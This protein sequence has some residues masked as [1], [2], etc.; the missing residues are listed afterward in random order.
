MNLIKRKQFQKK[1]DDKKMMIK[2]LIKKSIKLCD[3]NALL[4]KLYFNKSYRFRRDNDYISTAI[5][6]TISPSDTNH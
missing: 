2:K 6:F 4:S 1:N 5:C 3:L